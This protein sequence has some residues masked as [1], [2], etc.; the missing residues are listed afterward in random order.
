MSSDQKRTVWYVD[1]LNSS[2]HYVMFGAKWTPTSQSLG[3]LHNFETQKSFAVGVMLAVLLLIRSVLTIFTPTLTW[4]FLPER[5]LKTFILKSLKKD[6]ERRVKFNLCA[7][8]TIVNKSPETIPKATI[9]NH[10]NKHT[11]TAKDEASSSTPSIPIHFR[12]L[13]K[14]FQ[15]RVLDYLSPTQQH[16]N[17][18][19]Q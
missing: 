5:K 6:K 15:L 16:D 8:K 17:L 7:S 3:C 19:F 12:F 4:N 14:I 10:N 1:L 2:Q 9:W 13:N 18:K 11:Q